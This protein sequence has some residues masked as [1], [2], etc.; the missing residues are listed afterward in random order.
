MPPLATLSFRGKPRFPV[1]A[2]KESQHENRDN[3]CVVTDNS[4]LPEINR[5]PKHD[6][7]GNGKRDEV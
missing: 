4:A 2:G 5:C 6:I 3:K 1:F 7:G